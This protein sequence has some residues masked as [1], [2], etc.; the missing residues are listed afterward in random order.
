MAKTYKDYSKEEIK[1]LLKQHY[2]AESVV[3]YE[4]DYNDEFH[5]LIRTGE[6]HD[7][8]SKTVEAVSTM[9]AV[10]NEDSFSDSHDRQFLFDTIEALL[11]GEELVQI[12]AYNKLADDLFWREY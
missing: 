12:G 2:K 10:R 7:F 3:Q 6:I 5:I 4:D 9:T 11:N 8:E 1:E